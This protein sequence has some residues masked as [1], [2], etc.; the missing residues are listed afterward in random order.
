VWKIKMVNKLLTLAEVA[1][2]L[3]IQKKTLYGWHWRRTNL[4]IVKIGR[5]LRIREKDLLAFIDRQTRQPERR[6]RE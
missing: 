3:G 6:G 5:V 4:P 2:I 1:S